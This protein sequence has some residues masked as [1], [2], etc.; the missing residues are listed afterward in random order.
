MCK[1]I[2][3]YSYSG[4][5]LNTNANEW[6]IIICVNVDKTQDKYWMKKQIAEECIIS[7]TWSLVKI[8]NHI[9]LYDL[10]LRDIY[11]H[12]Y[13]EI[14]IERNYKEKQRNGSFKIQIGICL[15]WVGAGREGKKGLGI[16]EEQKGLPRCWFLFYSVSC[17]MVCGCFFFFF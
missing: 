11:I 1:L 3:L 12:I 5:L 14:Y 2:V 8:Y 15:C 9:Q 7:F 13:M 4:L 16:L 10:L 17:G 6:S